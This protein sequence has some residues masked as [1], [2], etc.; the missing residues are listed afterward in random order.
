MEIEQSNL[1][2]E[3]DGIIYELI[4]NFKDAFQK[5]SFEERLVDVLKNKPFI[6]GDISHEKLRLTGFV[7]TKDSTNSK[8]INNLE[9]FILEYCNFGSPFFVVKKRNS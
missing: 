4:Y 6:V 9:D 3:V 7:L 1:I 8:N 2:F 5:E